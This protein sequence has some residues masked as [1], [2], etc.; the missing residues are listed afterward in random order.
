MKNIQIYIHEANANSCLSKFGKDLFG[1]QYGGEKDTNF[2]GELLDRIKNYTDMN[3]GESTED[4]LVAGIRALKNCINKYPNEL[5]P[6]NA[7]SFR[8]I[9]GD[10]KLLKIFATDLS[11]LLPDIKIGDTFVGKYKPRNI[12]ESWTSVRNIAE[13]YSSEVSETKNLGFVLTIPTTDEFVFDSEFF[14]SIS[15]NHGEFEQFRF[16]KREIECDIEIVEIFR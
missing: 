13:K 14:D 1:S 11:V 4:D 10:Y 12:V 9:V 5:K 8:G 6:K 7:F 2:E 3:F 15:I 16:S